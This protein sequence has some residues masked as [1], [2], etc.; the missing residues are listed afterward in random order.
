MNRERLQILR[1]KLATVPDDRLRME[2][3]FD[4]LPEEDERHPCGF[5][6]CAAGWATT[7]PEF[8]AVGLV[9]VGQYIHYHPPGEKPEELV[10]HALS[11][12]F[13][14]YYRDRD[15]LFDPATYYD[16]DALGRITTEM[17]VARI[18]ELLARKET[19]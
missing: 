5:A 15:H 11:K 10:W 1:D 9:R 8:Q 6:G 13:D 3:W 12:F 2:R 7:I 16:R 18:D 4:H 19:A 14:L 17:V